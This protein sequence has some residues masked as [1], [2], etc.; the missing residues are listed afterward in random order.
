MTVGTDTQLAWETLG[1][2]PENTITIENRHVITDEHYDADTFMRRYRQLYDVIFRY[3]VHRLFNRAAAE[4]VTATVFLKVVENL[5]RFRGGDKA[6]SCW[7]W[8]IAGNEINSYLRDSV[9]RM[10]LTQ[11]MALRSA[12][13]NMD[14]A[15]TLQHRAEKMDILRR[16]IFS[17][18]PKYQTVITL[19]YLENKD[20]SEIAGIVG[21]S[22]A[23][24]RSQISRALAKLR[25]EMPRTMLVS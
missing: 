13:C 18:K 3:C 5:E 21:R 11:D 17:L 23:T 15:P 6:F 25:R 9:R 14:D 20:I 24:V 19:R 2:V 8:R 16:A 10:K 4:D 22:E 12:G 1:Q 7:L